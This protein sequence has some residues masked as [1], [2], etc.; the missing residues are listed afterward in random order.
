[1]NLMSRDA[2][3]R[4]CECTQCRRVRRLIMPVRSECLGH[5]ITDLLC[6]KCRLNYDRADTWHHY[7]GRIE[8]RHGRSHA[9]P[10][11]CSLM[12][13]EWRYGHAP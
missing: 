1:V 9:V 11:P 7:Q 13:L 12:H 8:G 5:P 6:L 2:G 3:Q 10:V 4:D